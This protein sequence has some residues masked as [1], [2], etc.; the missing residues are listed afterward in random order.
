VL[1]LL[2]E[3]EIDH[4]I[5]GKNQWTTSEDI[6][7]KTSFPEQLNIDQNI[8]TCGKG[9]T[10]KYLTMHCKIFQIKCYVFVRVIYGDY[11]VHWALW[12]VFEPSPLGVH[13][14]KCSFSLLKLFI[15][16]IQCELAHKTLL[17]SVEPA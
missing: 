14:E 8:G 6:S 15:S 4:G 13:K 9:K 3:R 2:R 10:G 1:H 7:L 5:S 16:L 17:R 11:D 12:D